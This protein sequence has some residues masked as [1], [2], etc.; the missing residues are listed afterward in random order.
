MKK[1][2]L[3]GIIGI[4]LVGCVVIGPIM[5][6]VEQPEYQVVA[7]DGNIEIRQYD[8]MVIANV[9]MQGE[10]EDSIGDGFR[11]LADYIFGNNTKEKE[12]AMTAPVQQKATAPSVDEMSASA[13]T[14]KKS[15]S[16]RFVMP[17]KYNLKTLPKPK[18]KRIKLQAIPAKLY[19]VI[20]F[21]GRNSNDN[22]DQYEEQLSTYVEKNQVST[23]GSPIYAFYNPPWTLPPMRRN[24]ILIEIPRN[25]K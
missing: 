11:V 25:G 19:I 15:W 3:A 18:D 20:R 23:T 13:E 7:T 10:R 22:I 1:W 24:E 21:S 2:T 16:I 4:F 8:P 12:I 9:E 17:S 14:S 5:S 6:D